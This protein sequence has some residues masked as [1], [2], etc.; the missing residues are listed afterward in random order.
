MDFANAGYDVLHLN[1]QAT[2]EKVDRNPIPISSSYLQSYRV[3]MLD[4]KMGRATFKFKFIIF[5]LNFVFVVSIHERIFVSTSR[6]LVKFFKLLSYCLV[7]VSDQLFL[8]LF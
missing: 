7:D 5:L 1:H 6:A 4:S 2:T 3:L 8:V